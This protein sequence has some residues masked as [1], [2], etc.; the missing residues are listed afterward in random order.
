MKDKRKWVGP[1]CWYDVL[2]LLAV[3]PFIE[4]RAHSLDHPQMGGQCLSIGLEYHYIILNF[5][6]CILYI[7][8]NNCTS[9]HKK[10][11]T[12]IMKHISVRQNQVLVLCLATVSAS[13]S[14]ATTIFL[15]LSR[16]VKWEAHCC[17]P[18]TEMSRNWCIA[19]Y[20]VS[21]PAACDFCHEWGMS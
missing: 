21:L 7:F 17:F 12:Y 9:S 3:E 15:P 14:V 18:G 4:N 11:I 13:V 2:R 8:C 1:V 10:S 6:A 16:S 19:S 5:C 20:L